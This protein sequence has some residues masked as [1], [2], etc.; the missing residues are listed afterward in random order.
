[1]NSC[2]DPP[3]L[4]SYKF[5]C[6]SYADDIVVLSRSASGL[7]A[8]LNHLK[9]FC[10]TWCL[11]VNIK[12]TKIVIFS[13]CKS[14]SQNIFTYAD[15]QLET[16]DSFKYLGIH[17]SSNGTYK[18]AREELYKKGLKS[19]F[20]L[21]ST[22]PSGTNNPSTFM[23]LFDHIVKPSVLYGSEIWGFDT[24]K[25]IRGKTCLETIFKDIPAEKLH[26]KACRYTLGVHK[27]TSNLSLYG[28]LGRYP[29]YLDV[30][31]FCIKYWIRLLY[32]EDDS[33]LNLAHSEV[34]NL[35]ENG[36]IT[37]LNYIKLILQELNLS[38]IYNS[39]TSFKPSQIVHK[40]ATNLEMYIRSRWSLK[41]NLDTRRKNCNNKLRT[42]RKFKYIYSYERYLDLI[43]DVKLRRTLAQFRTSSH[44]LNIEKG[45]Y[46]NTPEEERT[47]PFC[48]NLIENEEH[49]LISWK[50]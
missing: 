5:N 48:P 25:R 4:L 31:I 22:L 17:F 40:V 44:T 45:R 15:K 3:Q 1:M 26:M 9:D 14:P 20:R 16:V 41:M 35:M 2:P 43:K 34:S 6:L 42:Y 33:L 7:Q 32:A 37:W 49:F 29:L 39:P 19:Y 10:E 11:E 36:T 50:K 24:S 47:C 23:H 30:I 38:Y 21:C 8:S 46:N 28:E 18:V 13:K 27:F 12:K